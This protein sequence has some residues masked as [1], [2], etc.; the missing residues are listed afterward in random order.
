MIPRWS[1]RSTVGSWLS[2]RLRSLTESSSGPTTFAFAVCD[3]SCQRFLCPQILHLYLSIRL[4]PQHVQ[5]ASA[6]PSSSI[7]HNKFHLLYSLLVSSHTNKSRKDNLKFHSQHSSTGSRTKVYF[8]LAQ[9]SRRKGHNYTDSQAHSQAGS[10]TCRYLGWQN[11]GVSE[12]GEASP[13]SSA[14]K[15]NNFY[16]VLNCLE[17]STMA[18]TNATTPKFQYCLNQQ[19]NC[20]SAVLPCPCFHTW[21]GRV[22]KIHISTPPLTLSDHVSLHSYHNKFM[23]SAYPYTL[24]TL[25]NSHYI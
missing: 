25:N 3:F 21:F 9:L 16:P 12:I 6:Y 7:S 18:P 10:Q 15:Q 5:H 20:F 19:Q 13:S 11:R 4:L 2:P 23:P 17:N 8:K 22:L 1:C 24:K 14:T